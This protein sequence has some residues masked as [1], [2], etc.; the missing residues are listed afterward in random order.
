MFVQYDIRHGVLDSK[1]KT[2]G[3]VYDVINVA[4][5]GVRDDGPSYFLVGFLI[6]RLSLPPKRTD[7]SRK[8]KYRHVHGGT[9]MVK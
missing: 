2:A 4:A 8:N 9:M 3:Q 6:L 1:A 7:L 5:R